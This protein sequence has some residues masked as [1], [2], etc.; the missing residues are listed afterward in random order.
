MKTN[1][2]VEFVFE[3][4]Y[5]DIDDISDT[6]G[7]EP[8]NTWE[9]GDLIKDRPVVRKQSCWSIGTGNKESLDINDQLFEMIEMLK[10]KEGIINNI[11]KKYDTT[12]FFMILIN[13]EDDEKPII[14]IYSPIIKFASSINAHLEIDWYIY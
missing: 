10:G 5:L 1:V 6:L 8:T 13:I 11:S 14:S 3:A 7:L 4:D 2:N 9:K 12:P